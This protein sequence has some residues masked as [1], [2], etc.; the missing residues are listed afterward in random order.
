M[1]NLN[2]NTIILH[3][4]ANPKWHVQCD[5][6]AVR[7]CGEKEFAV[8]RWRELLF[9]YKSEVEPYK[10]WLGSDWLEEFICNSEPM[11]EEMD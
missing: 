8:Q 7:V 9:A 5:R 3:S 11:V 6:F 1:L 4:D 2:P 10:D